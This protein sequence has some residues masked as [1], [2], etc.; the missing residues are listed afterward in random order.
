MKPR[1]VHIRNVAARCL[2][3]GFLSLLTTHC[4]TTTPA[5]QSPLASAPKVAAAKPTATAPDPFASPPEGGAMSD[6]PFPSIEHARLGNG[7]ELRTV[8]RKTYPIVELRLVLFSGS[9]SDGKQPGVAALAAELLKAGGA[10][11][12]SAAELSERAE[13]LG[14]SLDIQTGKD[15]T[16]ISMAVTTGDLDA[17]FDLIGAVAQRPRFDQKEF[18]KLQ[19]RAFEGAESAAKSSPEWSAS[20]V[21]ARELFGSA[22]AY[23]HYDAQASEIQALTLAACKQ[24]YTHNVTPLNAT[25]VVAG[26]VE[27][28]TVETAARRVFAGWRGDRPATPQSVAPATRD[29]EKI[30]V[31]DRPHAAQSEIYVAALGPERSSPQWPAIT[32][33]NQILG[34]GVAGRLFLDVREKRSLA[35]NTGSR[36]EEVARGPVPIVL[37][38]G[39][40][41]AKTDLALRALLE[42]S[43]RIGSEPPSDQEVGMATRSLSNSLLFRTETVA[44]VADLTA[45]LAVLGLADDYFDGYQHALAALTKT[46]VFEAAQSSF[47]FKNPVIVVAGD[48]SQISKP[49]SRLARVIT[50]DPTKDFQITGQIPMSGAQ[51]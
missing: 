48:A 25:L 2:G 46:T 31:V 36:L 23:G 38:A 29:E 7:L 45:K 42:N 35:Y 44:G 39:T 10:G 21:L 16:Q 20:M 8:T 40:Q 49:L 33:T 37:S 6:T 5:T 12:L 3:L 26:D 51:Q 22:G 28:S 34:G 4:A 19:R 18:Q 14:S 17:A 11:T 32:A 13:S 15:S 9:A 43:K 50:V 41:T 47:A 24:W 30:W 27:P 1:A